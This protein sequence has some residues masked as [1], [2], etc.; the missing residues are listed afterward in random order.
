MT[1]TAER[2]VETAFVLGA[3]AAFAAPFVMIG[4]F[5]VL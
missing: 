4:L 5:L 2:F 3:S 1:R